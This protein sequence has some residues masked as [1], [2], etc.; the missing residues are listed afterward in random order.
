MKKLKQRT[1]N[2]FMIFINLF[3]ITALVVTS[4]LAWFAINADNRVDTY[5][6]QVVSDSALMLSFDNSNWSNGLN[7][8][9]L[10][11]DETTGSQTII[12]TPREVLSTLRMVEVTGDGVTLRKPVL[13]QHGSYADVAGYGWHSATANQDYL[14]FTVYFKSEEPLDVYL[15]SDSYAR[16]ST[17]TPVGNGCGNPV[18]STYTSNGGTPFSK[19]CIV[20]ALRVQ[21]DNGYGNKYIWITNPEY[22]LNNNVGDPNGYSMDTTVCTTAG[23]GPSTGIGVTGSPFYWNRSDIHY[24]YSETD[25]K[26]TTY[27]NKI[28]ELPDTV[29]NVPSSNNTYL[30]QLTD[31]DN[32]GIYTGSATFTVW[33]EG[34]DTEARR[35]LVDGKFNLSLAIDAFAV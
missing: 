18:A 23:T 27:S 17:D 19:D 7:L 13:N 5:E 8:A 11:V 35:A 32:D 10:R 24:Y 1:K 2:K 31:Q 6:V 15:S 28:T 21:Y 12:T 30:C 20:G 34:C 3:L 26:V 4:V 33:I 14:K 22:H 16:P 29:T 25:N 9:D